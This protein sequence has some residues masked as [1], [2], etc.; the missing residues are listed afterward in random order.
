M[1]KY[2]R[3]PLTSVAL[4]TRPTPAGVFKKLAG[5]AHLHACTNLDCRAVYED[6]CSDP[7]LNGRCHDC[8]G[9]RT[10]MWVRARAPHPCCVDNTEMVA[11]TDDL[12]R[13]DLAG[14]GPWFQCRTCA[15]CHARPVTSTYREEPR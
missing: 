11:G 3:K 15:R 12:I 14:P 13:Y 2:K 5:K 6:N 1:S 8:R 4:R 9:L 7:A 10:P